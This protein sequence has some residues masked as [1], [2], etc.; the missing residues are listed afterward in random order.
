MSSP[1]LIPEWLK[2]L[3]GILPVEI[4]VAGGGEE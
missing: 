1:E 3:L 2:E 4:R